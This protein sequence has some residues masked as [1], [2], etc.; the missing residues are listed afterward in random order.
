MTWP[1]TDLAT[2]SK[3]AASMAE[4]PPA[5]ARAL[6]TFPW[7]VNR[8]VSTAKQITSTTRLERTCV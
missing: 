1:P 7:S 5:S 6:R 3:A 8:A 4:P 2:Q